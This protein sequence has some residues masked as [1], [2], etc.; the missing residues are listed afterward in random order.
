MFQFLKAHVI[1]FVFGTVINYDKGNSVLFLKIFDECDLMLMDIVK[2]KGIG[3]TFLGIEADR[4]PLYSSDIIYGTALVEIRQRDMT[5][6]FVH[7]Y[8]CDRCGN[9]LDQGKPLIQIAF[10]GTVNKIF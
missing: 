2:R 10:I 5:V 9:L 7:S 3:I 8:R 4:N 1:E 6:F